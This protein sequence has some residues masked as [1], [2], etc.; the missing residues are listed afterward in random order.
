M[1]LPYG[2]E[3]GVYSMCSGVTVAV[4]GTCQSKSGVERGA[5]HANKTGTDGNLGMAWSLFWDGVHGVLEK[6]KTCMRKEGRRVW[7]EVFI[8]IGYWTA[9]SQ[10]IPRIPIGI[11]QP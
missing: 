11:H 5:I 2:G 6:K 7:V 8:V 1:Q 3:F 4:S 10:D 9:L